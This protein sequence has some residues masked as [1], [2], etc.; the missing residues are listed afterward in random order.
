MQLISVTT[1]RVRL[2]NILS[3]YVH[4]RQR[5][6]YRLCEDLRLVLLP[7]VYSAKTHLSSVR[8]LFF[9]TTG[10][11]GFMS[12]GPEGTKIIFQRLI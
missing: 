6:Q 8:L 9:D 10:F 7:T 12:A 1:S 11:E 4:I 3:E 5:L 2:S